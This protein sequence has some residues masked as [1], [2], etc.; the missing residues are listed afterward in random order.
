M[1][2]LRRQEDAARSLR[3]GF[4][5]VELVV[6][7]AI[8]VMVIAVAVP[9]V[10]PV[11]TF[12]QLDSSARHIANYGLS[13][14][15]YCA[16]KQEDVTFTY[17]F[18]TQQYYTLRWLDETNQ[19]FDPNAGKLFGDTSESGSTGNGAPLEITTDTL[20]QLG[21]QGQLTAEMQ[22]VKAQFDRSFLRSLQAQARTAS[23]NTGVLAD[24]GPL[25]DKQ[26]KL[27][28]DENSNREEISSGLLD[29]TALP[30][31]VV[32]ESIRVGNTEY[33][34]GQVE[35]EI[36]PLGMNQFVVFTLKDSTGEYETVI[37]D[38]ITANSHMHRGQELPT[39]TKSL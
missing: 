4:T 3:V 2:S 8:I 38:P 31:N 12:G 28:D 35:I 22:Q 15:S 32:V 14:V 27:K 39:D 5:L 24:V 34:D 11:L 23:K 30:S 6:V 36:S 10:T 29:R 1:N 19:L 17:D 7:L 13:L 37:W 20:L 33:R 9:R 21:A 25:F 16:L 26:F 18:Q